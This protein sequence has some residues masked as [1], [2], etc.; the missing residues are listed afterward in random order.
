MF[1][2][3]AKESD[4][5]NQIVDM[6]IELGKDV[7]VLA[8]EGQNYK[9]IKLLRE[10]YAAVGLSEGK[11]VIDRYTLYLKAFEDFKNGVS[12]YTEY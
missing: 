2:R 7:C 1:Y 12:V 9:A 8:K 5:V 3:L 10:T 4:F 11:E 6:E